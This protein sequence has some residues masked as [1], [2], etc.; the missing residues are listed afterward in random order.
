MAN[1][2]FELQNNFYIGAYSTAINEGSDLTDLDEQ[3]A[4]ER[5][6]FVHRSYIANGSY[7]MA[8]AEIS[9]DAPMALQAVK[10]LAQF[11]SNDSAKDG[12]LATLDEWLEDPACNSNPTVLIMA[13]TMYMGAEN[14]EKALKCCQSHATLEMLAMEVQ[15]CLKMNRPDVA[16]KQL[17]IMS[18]MDDDATLTQL[19]T[20]WVG[21]GLGGAKVQ[22]AAYIFQELGDKYNWTVKLLNGSACCNMKM[23]RPE[24]AERELL[25]ALTKDGKDSNTLANLVVCALALGKSTSRYVTQL[26]LSAPDHPLVVRTAGHSEAFERAAQGFA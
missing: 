6:C 11:M 7:D 21:I 8:M 5:D 16:E 4:V 17:K 2:L 25:D 20:A 24:E 1:L 19:A 15:I 18:A 23:G 9:S 13:A 26:K 22:E 14:F 12:V 10:L 3:Q